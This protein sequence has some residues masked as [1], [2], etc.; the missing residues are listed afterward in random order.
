[1]DNLDLEVLNLREACVICRILMHNIEP[2]V[3]RD[4]WGHDPWCDVCNAWIK[5]VV[6]LAEAEQKAHAMRHYAV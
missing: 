4:P 6:E 5:L 3:D 2:G 1:M